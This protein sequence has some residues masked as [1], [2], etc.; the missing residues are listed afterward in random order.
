MVLLVG[1]HPTL[2]VDDRLVKLDQER[3]SSGELLGAGRVGA[4]LCGLF[5]RERLFIYAFLLEIKSTYELCTFEDGLDH[6]RGEG[7]A[8]E[9]LHVAGDRDVVCQQWVVIVD[10][11]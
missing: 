5:A 6:S 3:R 11:V 8:V 1:L 9:A 10:E 2:A 7:V 4:D